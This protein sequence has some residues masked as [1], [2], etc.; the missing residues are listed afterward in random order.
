MSG[1]RC[2]D[3]LTWGQWLVET[4]DAVGSEV[5]MWDGNESCD[6]N[7]PRV[8]TWWLVTEDSELRKAMPLQALR[9]ESSASSLSKRD[10]EQAIK[11]IHYVLDKLTE[12]DESTW[13]QALRQGI[14]TEAFVHNLRLFVVSICPTGLRKR[15][16]HLASKRNQLL[17][18]RDM[19]E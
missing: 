19:N 11:L 13:H 12:V 17:R 5:P 18:F 1:V 15:R 8:F 4:I 10:K 3:D 2:S 7:T 9:P 6:A 14:A 16:D